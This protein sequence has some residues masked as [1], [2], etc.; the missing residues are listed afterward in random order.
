MK[1]FKSFLLNQVFS[2]GLAFGTFCLLCLLYYGQIT[3]LN[4]LADNFKIEKIILQINWSDVLVGL[5]IYLKT[6]IDFAL[7]ISLL[8]N[9]YKGLKNRAIIEIGT[10]LGNGIGTMAVLVVWFFFKEVVWL[11]ALMIFLASLVLF[12]LALT[13]LEHLEIEE[14]EN[15]TEQNKSNHEP[16]TL[17]SATNL[18]INP[19][20]SPNFTIK[21][22][23]QNNNSKYNLFIK[24]ISQ[25]LTSFLTPLNRFISPIVSR[26]TP[27]LTFDN[28]KRGTKSLIWASFTIPFILGLDDFAGYVP[29]F[30]TVKVFGFGLGVFLGHFILNFLLFLNPNWTMRFIK[31]SLIAILGSI[32]FILLGFWGIWE[33][34]HLLAKY[35]FH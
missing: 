31:N 27:D 17:K 34:I 35:Y 2:I 21:K 4:S 25:F 9:Q 5:T 28:K 29:L 20:N 15:Q 18:E 13:S 1:N 6:S 33:V 24:Q 16:I 10:A 19:E 23:S 14:V 30:S 32:A 12:K 8:I 22:E 3:F 26:I 11:L 7:L